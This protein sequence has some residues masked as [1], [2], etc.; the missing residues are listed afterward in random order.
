MSGFGFEVAS[1]EEGLLN[2]KHTILVMSG[3]GGVGKSFI[4]VNIAAI[5]ASQG[6]QVGVL[7]ADIHG[8]SVPK[9]L[10]VDYMRLIAPDPGQPLKPLIGPNNIKVISIAFLLPTYDTPVVWRGPLKA[11]A[12]QEFVKN[13]DWGDLDYLLVDLPPGTGDEP[14]SVAQ[15][16]R[17]PSGAIIV[18]IPSEVSQ[19]VVEKAVNFAFSLKIPVIGI[20]ENMSGFTCP[21][22][23]KTYKIFGEGGGER[24]AKRMKVPFLGKIPLD[25]RITEASDKGRPFALSYP[26]T[27]ASKALYEIAQKIKQFLEQSN[28]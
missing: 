8:P 21:E 16:L 3:K 6:S 25:P 28:K 26:N 27:P 17:R 2:I 11:K 14:L 4:T 7:D 5:L 19:I 18:T 13:L 24:I 10:G 22:S 9:M 23:G 20:V 1:P 15:E 12:I